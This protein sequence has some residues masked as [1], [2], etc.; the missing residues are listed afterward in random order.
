MGQKSYNLR[1]CM[2]KVQTKIF[3]T[4]LLITSIGVLGKPIWPLAYLDDYRQFLNK[5]SRHSES[6]LFYVSILFT[7]QQ[8]NREQHLMWLMVYVYITP[9]KFK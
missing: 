3:P 7:K 1:V 4:C 6:K 2:C 8:A 5:Y 9:V